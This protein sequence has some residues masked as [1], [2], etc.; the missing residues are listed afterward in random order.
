MRNERA[1]G[2]LLHTGVA[3][4]GFLLAYLLVAFFLFPDDGAAEELRVPTVIGLVFDDAREKLTTAGFTASLGQARFS[5]TAP[6]STVL[7]QNPVG[8]TRLARGSDVALDVSEGQQSQTIPALGGLARAQATA[9]LRDAGLEMGRIVE[10][11]SE[12]P[13]GQV[14]ESNPAAGQ[15]VPSGTSIDLIVSGG[16]AQLSMPDLVGRDLGEARSMLEQLGLALGEPERDSLSLLPQNSIIE[17]TPAAGAP[18]A[19]G[20]TVAIRVAGRP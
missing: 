5:A 1:R 20:T 12:S 13:R 11:A 2:V 15:I 7:E 9:A 16:P 17:Q 6:K 14:L 10:M 4:G 19:P 8:G 3:A 18:V